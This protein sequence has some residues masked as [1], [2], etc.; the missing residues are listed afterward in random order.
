[1]NNKYSV[2]LVTDTDMCPRENLL[3]VV[4]E[5]IRGGVTT[6]QLREKDISTREFYAEALALKKLCGENNV[7]L[8]INDRVDIALAVDADG[9]HIGQ[10]D[11]PIAVARRILGEN[12]IIGLSA[13]NV[14]E[15]LE[16]VRG[17]ADYLGVG[18]VFHTAT[19]KDAKDV[20]IDMLRR[21]RAAAPIPIVGIGGINTENID[22]LFG[23]GIDGV[24][25]VSCIMASENPY[26]AAK[27]LSD[28]I[29]FLAVR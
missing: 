24:A 4:G 5:A 11:M 23:I 9:I 29:K 14:T 22:K 20:G 17:G 10:S 15:A 3:T 2:Y 28:K 1:V 13:G 6:V 16:A 18:A 25:V 12:K 7:P 8:I 27:T 26:A 21:V 19:K